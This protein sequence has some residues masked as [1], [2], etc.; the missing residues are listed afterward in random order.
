M[1]TDFDM[2]TSDGI[3]GSGTPIDI[4]KAIYYFAR[5]WQMTVMQLEELN[6]IIEEYKLLLGVVGR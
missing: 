4:D 2:S 3:Y 1:K 6:G 5:K